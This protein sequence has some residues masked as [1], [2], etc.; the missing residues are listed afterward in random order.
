MGGSLSLVTA[1]QIAP[2]LP[3]THGVAASSL[4]SQQL[5]SRRSVAPSM[6]EMDGSVIAGAGALLVGLGGGVALI[7]FTENAGKRNDAVEN[8]Q[9]CV[10]CKAEKVTPCTICQGTGEDQYASLVKGVKDMVEGEEG[11]SGGMAKTVVD[12][13]DAGSKEV[14]MYEE[15]LAKFPVKATTNV[16]ESCG[17]RGV[18]VCD[19]CQGT[20]IQPVSSSVTVRTTSWIRRPARRI[21]WTREP[22]RMTHGLGNRSTH[23]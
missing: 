4:P 20:G 12:D 23:R 8:A 9:P 21:I 13:W 16:C 3:R 18:V 6:I 2:A 5:L 15:I 22:V 7:A 10:V 1:F 11:T 19:N 17:G 14:V